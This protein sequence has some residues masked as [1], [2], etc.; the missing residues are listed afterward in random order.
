M[1]RK[2]DPEEKIDR[3]VET[4]RKLFVEKGFHN[5][6]IPEVVKASGVSTGAI[7]HHFGNKENLA[8]HIYE[9]TLSDYTATLKKRLIGAASARE[10]LR[11]CALLGFEIAEEDP[12][13]MEYMLFM[14]HGEFMCD[15]PPVC[16]GQPFAWVQETVAK[17]MEDGE[18]EPGNLLVSAASFTG[19]I[20]RMIQLHLD[21][22]SSGSLIQNFEET[23]RNA[24]A[25]V[26]KRS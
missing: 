26:A 22:V 3:V 11:V 9:R 8:R 12:I 19:V 2:I 13:M 16:L 1:G 4:A 18:I 15:T 7:Y 17:G 20:L 23:F 25:A 21:G 10:K 24:W 5:V 14:R 6:S